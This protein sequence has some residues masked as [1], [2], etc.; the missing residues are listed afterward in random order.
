[1]PKSSPLETGSGRPYVCVHPKCHKCM[2][3]GVFCTRVRQPDKESCP[4]VN[5]RGT[6][7]SAFEQLALFGFPVFF[8]LH[9]D[10]PYKTEN[11]VFRAPGIPGNDI[12][13]ACPFIVARGGKKEVQRDSFQRVVDRQDW[14][15]ALGLW[16]AAIGVRTRPVPYDSP[17]NKPPVDG[18]PLT[19]INNSLAGRAAAVIAVPQAPPECEIGEKVAPQDSQQACNA[20][21]HHIACHPFRAPAF[22]GT[23]HSAW[24][25][26]G[27]TFD[28]PNCWWAD[29]T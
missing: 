19:S 9:R 8:L 13:L 1:M 3:F 17:A 26:A 21:T 11:L 24:H 7:K 23:R 2:G 29:T 10:P 20:P 27:L 16:E 12:F 22:S 4:P 18:Q 15:G 28:G 5:P 14:R 25:Y 6:P